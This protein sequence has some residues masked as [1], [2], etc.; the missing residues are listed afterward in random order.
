MECSEILLARNKETWPP[1]F[2]CR[3]CSLACLFSLRLAWSSL[4]N[5]MAAPGQRR[6]KCGVR[7]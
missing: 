3:K 1:I 5:N 6:L 2:L 4:M 7:Y